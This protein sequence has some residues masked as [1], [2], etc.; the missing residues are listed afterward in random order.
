MPLFLFPKPVR[1][2]VP[3]RQEAEENQKLI[4]SYNDLLD[5]Y[6]KTGDGKTELVEASKKLVDVFDI[7]NGSLLIL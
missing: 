2:D 1:P 6:K 5:V 3:P 4:N 7:E